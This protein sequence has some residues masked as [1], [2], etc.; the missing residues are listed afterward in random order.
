MPTI[1]IDN[2]TNISYVFFGCQSLNQTINIDNWIYDNVENMEGTFGDCP[3]FDTL[4]VSGWNI[5]N[6]TNI[7]VKLSLNRFSNSCTFSKD[8]F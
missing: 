6:V 1:S 8:P 5:S 2:I 4:N 3:A 7:G